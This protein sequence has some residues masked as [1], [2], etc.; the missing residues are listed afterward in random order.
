MPM[1]LCLFSVY[2]LT[3]MRRREALQ[4]EAGDFD[5]ARATPMLRAGKG[6]RARVVPGMWR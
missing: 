3:G 4:L 6:G 1:P 5:P 2:A